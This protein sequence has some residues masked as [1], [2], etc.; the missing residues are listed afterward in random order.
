[1]RQVGQRRKRGVI[2]DKYMQHILNSLTW[3]EKSTMF[4]FL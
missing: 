2:D 3:K 4:K 1:M